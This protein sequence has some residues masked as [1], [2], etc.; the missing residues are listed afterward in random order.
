MKT[1]PEPAADEL[2]LS[3]VLRTLSDPS[4][5]SILQ[6]LASG[7]LPCS[8]LELPIAKSTLSQHLKMLREAG[9]THT[10]I[11][12]RN[13][14]ATLRTDDLNARF[15]GLLRAVGITGGNSA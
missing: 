11:E 13:H 4:R 1:L 8:A 7:P 12:G 2:D 10:Q 9:L 3:R 6:A 15:P 14:I 5:R